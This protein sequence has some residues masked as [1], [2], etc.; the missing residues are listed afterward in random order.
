MYIYNIYICIVTMCYNI[1]DG[2]ERLLRGKRQ[3]VKRQK[4]KG[5][6]IWSYTARIQN[7]FVYVHE[8]ML[9]FI[10]IT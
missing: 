1:F 5:M 7:F 10:S 6:R 9:F 8:I 3:E 4:A 2:A